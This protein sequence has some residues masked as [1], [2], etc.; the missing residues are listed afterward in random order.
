MMPIAKLMAAI[1]AP[2]FSQPSCVNPT[3]DAAREAAREL[4]EQGSGERADDKEKNRQRR[5]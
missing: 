4:H 5:E 1:A 2:P 3:I